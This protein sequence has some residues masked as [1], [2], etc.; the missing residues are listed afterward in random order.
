MKFLRD[1]R[2][3]W[4][5]QNKWISELLGYNFKIKPGKKSIAADA[6][7][8]RMQYS[9]IHTVKFS[10]WE[11]LQAEIKQDE[12]LKQIIQDLAVNNGEH[13][14]YKINQ[15]RLYYQGRLVIPKGSLKINSILR[16]FHDSANIQKYVKKCEVCQ[17]NKYPT[18]SPARLLQP[19]PVPKQIWADISMYFIGGLPKSGG[20]DGH[21]K[22]VAKLFLKEVLKLHGFS[23]L[24]VSDRDKVFMSSFWTELFKLAG[25]KLKRQTEVVNGCLETYLMCMTG[26]TPFKALYGRDPPPVV[27]G[28]VPATPMEEVAVMLKPTKIEG[29]WSIKGDGILEIHPYK[30]KTLAK[31]VNQKL[32]PRYYG[33]YEIMERIGA[34]FT[35]VADDIVVQQLYPFMTEELELEVQPEKVLP[36]MEVLVKWKSLPACE[37]SWEPLHKMMES[38]PEL[39]LEDKVNFQGVGVD[40]NEGEGVQGQ[41]R[42]IHQVY[43]RKKWKPITWGPTCTREGIKGVRGPGNFRRADRLTFSLILA[44][45][46]SQLGEVIRDKGQQLDTPGQRQLVALGRALLQQSRIL[47]L[48]EAT[49][50][51]DTATDN[52]IQK[53][54]RS[55]FKACTVCTIAHR[56]PTVIDSDQVLVLSDGRVAEYDTPT[57]LLEDKSSMFLKLVTEY[58]SRSSGIPEF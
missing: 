1:Q 32:N 4:E 53:I 30:L 10:E 25:T 50:S 55:E 23:K 44:L 54:I 28:D 31:R 48:D 34:E 5:E 13:Q 51:V 39:H 40:T 21:T 2:L 16:E 38:F 43:E 17:I 8:R 26:L 11:D 9:A 22:E 42:K 49:A 7:S 6:L 12:R 46:K 36:T 56:I 58:S 52:L 29:K 27:R 19:L 15:G 41:R 37:N 33:H 14:G 35:L 3:I 57:R 47:V 18:L 24:I 20:K 45:D